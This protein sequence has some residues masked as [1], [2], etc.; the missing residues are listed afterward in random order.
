MNDIEIDIV[1]ADF[2]VPSRVLK[3]TATVVEKKPLVVELN[4]VRDCNEMRCYHIE[5]VFP[6]NL[7]A[8]GPSRKKANTARLEL[9]RSA[10]AKLREIGWT[11]DSGLWFAPY[12][13]W[14]RL[15]GTIQ[16]G[17]WS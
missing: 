13:V 6:P 9:Y 12:S 5:S 4:L 15:L 8:G 2:T 11:E 16:T 1:L 10:F 3:S 14:S 17:G 7:P